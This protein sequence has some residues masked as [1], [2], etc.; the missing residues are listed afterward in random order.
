MFAFLFMIVSSSMIRRHRTNH[1]IEYHRPLTNND[2]WARYVQPTPR[3]HPMYP[4]PVYEEN[5]YYSIPSL[6]DSSNPFEY[7]YVHPKLRN[8]IR[9]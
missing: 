8:G 9:G 1:H 4:N 2:P 3:D 5:G 7:S 6:P